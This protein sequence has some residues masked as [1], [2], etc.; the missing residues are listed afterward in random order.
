M[1]CQ[2]RSV[3]MKTFFRKWIK[4]A[5]IIALVLVIFF[6]I[7]HFA[8]LSGTKETATEDADYL[9]VLG[10]RLHG[11]TM[12]LSLYHRMETALQY[13][14]ENPKTKVIVSG[15]QGPGES[16]TEAEAMARF[17][18]EQGIEEARIILE[19]RSTSTFENLTFSKAL[20]ENES[21]H[22]VIISNDFHL[23]RTG[24]LANR[25]DLEPEFLPA[26][27]PDII[28]TKMWAREYIAVIKSFLFDR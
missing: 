15:G 27:T 22:L 9:I 24:L 20:L 28:K 1:Y 7:V 14:R 21:S 16:I 26:P 12:S 4:I 3:R 17:L 6:G 25:L 18:I 13:L 2:K 10:A 11:E 19:D 8:I 5:L 23:F